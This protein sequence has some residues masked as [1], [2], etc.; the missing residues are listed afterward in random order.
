MAA[1]EMARKSFSTR[2]LLQKAVHFCRSYQPR[3][4]AVMANSIAVIVFYHSEFYHSEGGGAH[5]CAP[6]FLYFFLCTKKFASS[7]RVAARSPNFCSSAS[8]SLTKAS[9]FA[10][11]ASI[12]N[13]A[14]YVAFSEA[15]ALK[16]PWR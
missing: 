7:F 13:N 10:T 12:P 11:D 1:I 16:H 3:V 4:A 15:Q 14:G 8:P 9:A 2:V 6:F 5:N